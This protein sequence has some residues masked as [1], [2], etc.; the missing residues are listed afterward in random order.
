MSFLFE[1]AQITQAAKVAPQWEIIAVA[2][3]TMIGGVAVAL[4]QSKKAANES[5]AMS[6]KIGTPNGK[7]NVV[8]MLERLIHG[9]GA[10]DEQLKSINTRL[11]KGDRRFQHIEG[12]ISELSTNVTDLNDVFTG[13]STNVT[14]LNE[15]VTELRTKLEEHLEAS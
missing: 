2:F 10:Q 9:Q 3:I 11:D 15:V 1:A 14:D 12:E 8:Q 4:I 7:G 13:L 6:A 5:R